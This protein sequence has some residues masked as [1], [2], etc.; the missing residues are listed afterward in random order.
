MTYATKHSVSAILLQ[1][2][3]MVVTITENELFT[4]KLLCPVLCTHQ[5]ATWPY[6]TPN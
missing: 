4:I 2:L 5:P 1:R 3:H 6:T